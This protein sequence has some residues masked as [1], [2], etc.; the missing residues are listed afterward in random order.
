M[1]TVVTTIR[2]RTISRGRPR[3]KLTVVSFWRL[4]FIIIKPGMTVVVVVAAIVHQFTWLQSTGGGWSDRIGG[5]YCRT[6]PFVSMRQC[7]HY[8]TG[9]RRLTRDGCIR[10]YFGRF[11][12]RLKLQEKKWCEDNCEHLVY[13]IT[14]G[15]EGEGRFLPIPEEEH[16]VTGSSLPSTSSSIMDGGFK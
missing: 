12:K 6:P 10:N 4:S 13:C 2:P 8:V 3:T 15:N 16:K 5:H 1:I 11:S 9:I 7:L 14:R